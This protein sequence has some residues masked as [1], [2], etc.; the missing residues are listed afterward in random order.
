[1]SFRRI[2]I[3]ILILILVLPLVGCEDDTLI[4]GE[5]V[6]Y[7]PTTEYRVFDIVN[8][9]AEDLKY[10]YEYDSHGSVIRTEMST[11]VRIFYTTNLIVD[12]TY[13]YDDN[14]RITKE[15]SHEEYSKSF[16]GTTISDFGNDY[17]YNE[18]GLL[19]KS[20]P[21]SNGDYIFKEFNY[22]YDSNGNCIKENVVYNS[23]GNS[24]LNREFEYDSNGFLIKEI[25][26]SSYED[27]ALNY[28]ANEIVYTYDESQ[29][30]ESKKNMF[31]DYNYETGA[32]ES[33][34]HSETFY[35]YDKQNR[36]IKEE[37]KI[38][39]TKGEYKQGTTKTYEDFITI[40]LNDYVADPITVTKRED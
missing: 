18:N 29:R 31:Y 16:V 3:F 11:K 2:T 36:I 35:T 25:H 40:P 21:I 17:I 14:N 15:T 6:I 27:S 28:K 30:L 20:I 4:N 10:E 37:S 12:T 13:V 32:A 33:S 39:N 7:L 24:A 23:S 19:I 38:Y 22:V 1:M 34:G 9:G 8:G 5:D 26:Y